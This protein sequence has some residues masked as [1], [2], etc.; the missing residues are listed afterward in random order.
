MVGYGQHRARHANDQPIGSQY[1]APVCGSGARAHE[2]EADG[3]R[4]TAARMRLTREWGA[5]GQ[6][7]ATPLSQRV[8]VGVRGRRS[9]RG[10]RGPGDLCS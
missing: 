6:C 9:P 10:N 2:L 8:V 3:V 7:E 4:V 5:G 1:D